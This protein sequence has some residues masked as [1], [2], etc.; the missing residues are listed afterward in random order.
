MKQKTE[1]DK[2]ASE[3]GSRIVQLKLKKNKNKL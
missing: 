1:T 3:K 2:A